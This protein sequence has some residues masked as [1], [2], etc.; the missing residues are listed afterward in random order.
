MY[1]ILHGR[2]SPPGHGLDARG[3]VSLGRGGKAG[4]TGTSKIKAAHRPEAGGIHVIRVME[5][6]RGTDPSSLVNFVE[7]A[8]HGLYY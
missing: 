8:H 6:I 4:A 1:H 3:G 7:T 5:S 2:D